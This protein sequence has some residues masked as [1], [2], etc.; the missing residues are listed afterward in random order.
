MEIEVGVPDFSFGFEVARHAEARVASAIE[1]MGCAG[2]RQ[3]M[4]PSEA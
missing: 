4:K 3:R 2:E 1:Q